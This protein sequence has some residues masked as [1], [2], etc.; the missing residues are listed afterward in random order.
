[1]RK[2][3]KTST[4]VARVLLSLPDLKV[5]SDEVSHRLYM[6]SST[7]RR[8]L[9]LEETSFQKILHAVKIHRLKKMVEPG[10]KPLPGKCYAR[11]LGFTSSNAFYRFFQDQTGQGFGDFRR[12]A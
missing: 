1:M 7:M 4:R 11:E 3:L 9:K 5:T 12:A 10:K 8:H 2:D 6:S